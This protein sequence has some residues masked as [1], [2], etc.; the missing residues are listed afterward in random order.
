MLNN[1]KLLFAVYYRPPRQLAADRDIFLSSLTFSIELAQ[2]SGAD[3]I[4]ATGDFNDRCKLWGDNHDSSEL[5]CL[6]RD[7]VKDK[8]L[9]QIINQP[10][11]LAYDCSPQN[12]LDLVNTDSPNK[13]M[14][15]KVIPHLVKI[16]HCNI[17]C[18]MYLST[19]R[20]NVFKR[21]VWNYKKYNLDGLVEALSSAPWDAGFNVFNDID[22]IVVIVITNADC[23]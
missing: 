6:L 1:Y 18:K 14:E 23:S 8:C 4:V 3:S 11:R 17:I 5:R 22:D 10:T 15:C 19:R 9:T 21:T 16:D 12:L 2:D 7:L 20:N 13:F